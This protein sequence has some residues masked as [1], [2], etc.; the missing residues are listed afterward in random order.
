MRRFFAIALI[1]SL[2]LP[3]CFFDS[4]WGSAKR[5]QTAALAR[6]APAAL[7]ATP[8]VPGETEIPARKPVR[9]L[10]I[11]A[12]ATARYA[13]EV[14]DW[15]RQLAELLDDANEVLGPTLG[16]R[17]EIA[18]TVPWAPRAGEDDLGGLLAELSAE[19]PGPDA[20][21]VLGLAAALPRAE[22][23]FHQLGMATMPGRHLVMRAMNDAREYE[24]IE[25][26]F[27]E[28]DPAER[29][30]L[31]RARKR[32]KAATVFLHE[33][34]HTLG[35]PH[36][37]LATT[38]MAP[39]YG[40][41]VTGFSEAA[42]E[43][44]RLSLDHRL[45]PAAQTDQAFAEA[46][47]HAVERSAASWVD[48]EREAL[49]ARLRSLAQPPAAPRPA[50]G[51]RRS[52]APDPTPAV[53]A[54]P[55][56]DPLAALSPPDRQT[57]QRAVEDLAAGRI[58]DARRL[59]TPLFSA[60]PNVNEVQDFRCKLAMTSGGAFTVIKAECARLMELTQGKKAP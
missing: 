15:P 26:G 11:Q 13:A 59:S 1:A 29:R 31:Y 19:A 32:H 14:V 12:R 49:L 28:I 22:E 44:L 23:S 18:S 30:R 60:Y 35:V 37:V 20:T 4:Q 53:P 5:A 47:L 8:E 58:D 3:A 38:V 21:W 16:I 6:A 51:R 2:S 46:F 43:L 36:E 48:D 10:R 9:T 34:G 56:E 24:A 39:R 25:R 17:V 55:A 52:P 41:K 50:R 54:G 7:H 33:I 45:A 57:Y 27:T 42:A 40:A